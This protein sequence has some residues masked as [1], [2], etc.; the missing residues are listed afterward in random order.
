MTASEGNTW[1]ERGWTGPIRTSRM[2]SF[3]FSK[4]PATGSL[5]SRT[6]AEKRKNTSIASCAMHVMTYLPSKHTPIESQ[7]TRN[8]NE[9]DI[10]GHLLAHN[11]VNNVPRDERSSGEA[12]LHTIS[13]DDDIGREHTLDRSHDARGR[14]VLPRIEGRLKKNDDEKDESESKVRR[15]RVRI[16]QRLP[17]GSKLQVTY[18]RERRMPY[19]AMKQTTLAASSRLPKPPKIQPMTLRSIRLG[20]GEIWLAPYCAVRRCA[21]AASRPVF[22]ATANRRSASSMDTRCQSSSDRSSVT[23]RTRRRE[24]MLVVSG[25]RVGQG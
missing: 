2:L 11:Q 5:Y 3:V 1:V 8:V 10:R 19:Q 15:L 4:R 13:E 17:A 21:C 16:S 23:G 12:R 25:G 22:G 14:K 9:P 24:G 20:G 6:L 7:V 18:V